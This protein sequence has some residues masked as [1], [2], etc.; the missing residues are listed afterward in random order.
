MCWACTASGQKQI[1][2]EGG[3]PRARAKVQVRRGLRRKLLVPRT[4]CRRLRA[5]PPPKHR[6]ARSVGEPG[7][8][9]GAGGPRVRAR[10]APHLAA[11][12][13]CDPGAS[14]SRLLELPSRAPGRWRLAGTGNY[15]SQKARSTW[16]HRESAPGGAASRRHRAALGVGGRV[17]GPAAP[18][19]G[20]WPGWGD[21]AARSRADEQLGGG[22]R[23]L[24]R[25]RQC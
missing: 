6:E 18:A 14:S 5:P 2:E 20:R 15:I 9:A 17:G 13:A 25:P 7:A 21:V 22:A 3:G 24:R 12:A 8:G 23:L 19:P 10:A 4:R 11:P 16:G 1:S